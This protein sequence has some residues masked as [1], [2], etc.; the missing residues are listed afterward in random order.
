MNIY[1]QHRSTR[2]DP[3]WDA[4]RRRRVVWALKH[5]VGRAAVCRIYRIS[6]KLLDRIIAEEG[7]ESTVAATARQRE[8]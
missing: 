2:L 1:D 3:R 7:L 8:M 6:K 4:S 5:G